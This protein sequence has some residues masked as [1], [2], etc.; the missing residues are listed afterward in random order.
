MSKAAVPLLHR[1][2]ADVGER[3]LGVRRDWE[4][5]ADV[6]QPISVAVGE[7]AQQNRVGQAK[8]GQRSAASRPRK[9]RSRERVPR[10][11]AELPNRVPQI[12]H[13][14]LSLARAGDRPA[15]P[16]DILKEPVT[17]SLANVNL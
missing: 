16:V 3:Q 6:H 1:A 9:C 10:S 13:H 11:R 5:H 15:S 2:I 8:Y 7:G 12:V 4:M 14:R 17:E